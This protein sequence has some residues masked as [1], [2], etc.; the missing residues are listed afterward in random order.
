VERL[1]EPL[2]AAI[3]PLARRERRKMNMAFDA[4]VKIDGIPGESTDDKHKNWIEILS[5]SH[6]LSQ[7]AS[8]ASATGGRTAERV[9]VQDFSVVKVMDKATPLLHLACCDGRHL[10]KIEV[11]I[12]EAGGN[13]HAY[14]KWTLEDAIISGVRPG[15]S[16]QGGESKP[17][18]EVSFN[19]GKVR[20]EYTPM[21]S[22]GSPG[23]PQRTG[24]SLETNAKL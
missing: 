3:G 19:F 9:N 24:W 6:G 22:R 13:K 15:G 14:M 4:F 8:A 5:F 16:A 18:E 1:E 2:R 11:E 23:S 20:W 21:D 12:C 17:L 10:S 7:P